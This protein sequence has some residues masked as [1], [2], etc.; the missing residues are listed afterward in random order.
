MYPSV[1]LCVQVHVQCT[2]TRVNTSQELNYPL[3]HKINHSALCHNKL[4]ELICVIN[5]FVSYVTTGHWEGH[6]PYSMIYDSRFQ[7]F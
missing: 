3:N 2:L 7:L 5:A 4:N 6:V 1:M